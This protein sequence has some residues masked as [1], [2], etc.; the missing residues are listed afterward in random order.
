MKKF[1]LSLSMLAALMV[2]NAQNHV[3]LWNS[4]TGAT[5]ITG[6]P[7]NFGVP[8]SNPNNPNVANPP[9]INGGLFVDTVT[10]SGVQ[11]ITATGSRSAASGGY[12]VGGFGNGSFQTANVGKPWGTN[13]TASGGSL[14]VYYFN[15]KIKSA[16]P[17]P[18][19]KIQLESKDSTN[20]QGYIVD[21]SAGTTAGNYQT[22]SIALGSFSNTIGQY[23]D[24]I[25][26]AGNFMTKKFADSLYKVGFSVN[27]AGLNGGEGAVTFS[28]TDIWIGNDILSTA[29][30]ANIAS[31]VVYP[32]PTSGDVK[33]NI[34]LQNPASVTMIVTDMVGKQ[35]ATKNFGTVS[36]LSDATVFDA[37][38]LA[39]GMYTVTY[40][41]DGTPAKTELVVVK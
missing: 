11:T 17:G 23:G 26:T 15:F 34:T 7:F 30:A 10:I 33:V 8:D 21:L 37:A 31:S 22:V 40:V 27:N 29:A 6:V 3:V 24:P 36:S 28:I 20:V 41:L 25:A 1:L 5:Q 2:A 14:S 16:S 35:I 13:V 18:K 12:Y 38:G 9:A 39:K 19:I 4:A 32:N